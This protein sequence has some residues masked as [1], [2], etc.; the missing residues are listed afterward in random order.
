MPWR[1]VLAPRMGQQFSPMAPVAPP[2][3]PFIDSAFMSLIFDGIIVAG[4]VIAGM[5]LWKDAKSSADPK[6]KKSLK[7]W[8][9]AFYGISGLIGLKAVFDAGRLT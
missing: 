9:Y 4:G 8:S 7:N 5:G 6:K 1:P 2:A 3:P